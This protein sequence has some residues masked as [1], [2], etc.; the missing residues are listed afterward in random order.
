MLSEYDIVIANG[1]LV[2]AN[3][4]NNPDREFRLF[5][6]FK[7][8]LISRSILGSARWRSRQLGRYHF[9]HLQNLPHIQ[10]NPAPNSNICCYQR[11][12]RRS[13]RASCTSH[14]RLGFLPCWPVFLSL[15]GR[16]C[17]QCARDRDV[18]LERDDGASGTGYEALPRRG[19]GDEFHGRPREHNDCA[20]ER[21]AIHQ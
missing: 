17:R 7:L 10:R 12:D 15:L 6:N 8:E 9:S 13:F 19:E 11:F 20:A 4:A 16:I 21:P 3:D 1:E 14:L 5:N 18:L 2:T